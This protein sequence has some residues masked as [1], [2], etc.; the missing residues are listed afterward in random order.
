MS[1]AGLPDVQEQARL[2]IVDDEEM[3]LSSIRT[4]LKL[5]ESYQVQCF[6]DPAQALEH[7]RKNSLDLIIADYMMPNMDGIELLAQI[8]ALQPEATRILLTGYADKESAIRAINQ[9][10]LF[11]YLEKPWDNDQLLLAIRNGLEKRF[12]VKR[13]REKISELD[14]AHGGLKEVQKKLL[15]AFI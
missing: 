2:L 10:G 9:V 5:E 3:V 15:E 8:K 6:T 14:E 11:Q 12:L 1:T 4:F 13:L 7:A